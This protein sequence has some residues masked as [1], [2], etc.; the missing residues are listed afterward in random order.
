MKLLV[1]IHDVSPANC[2][3]VKELWRIAR[4]RSITPAL[5]VV[6]NWHGEWP[7]REFPEFVAWTRARADEGADV[8]LHGERH[9][10]VG[11]TRT[12]RDNI[13]ALGR[14]DAEAEFLTLEGEAIRSRVQRGLESLFACGIHPIGFVPPAWLA[15]P[16]WSTEM[17]PFGFRVSEDD[18]SVYLHERGTRIAAPV[19][20][21]STRT[22]LR[23]RLSSFVADTRW[24]ADPLARLMRI[25]L[26]PSDL[27]SSE[28]CQSIGRTLDRWLATH[29]PF[30][31]R[32]L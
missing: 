4:T 23:A 30:S 3:A 11:S 5:L 20:R 14:T 12:L 15:R 28:V 22:P 17:W 18:G 1:A 10:E 9:D 7:L 26:H 8:F 32:A 31:Y 25:A 21:W 6:P 29:Q 16:G 19:T 27:A 24:R 13:R 2:D